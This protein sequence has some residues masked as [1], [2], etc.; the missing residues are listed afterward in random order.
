MASYPALD[1]R[2]L[3]DEVALALVDDFGPLAAEAD[4]E[5]LVTIFFSTPALRDEARQALR[6]GAPSAS[7]DSRDIDDGGWAARS[8]AA[9]TPVSVGRITVAPPWTLE[10]LN[11]ALGATRDTVI[12]VIQPSMGFGTGHH[13]S[14]RLCLAALQT[15][16]LDGVSVL[17]VGTG[18]GVLA[19]AA[20]QLGART[21]VGIDFDPDAIQSAQ[22]NH[23][24]NGSP[25]GVTFRVA[26]LISEEI[27][28]F[29]VVLANLT[30]ALLER[31]AARLRR[32]LTPSGVLIVSGLMRHERDGVAAAFAPLAVRWEA[33]ED[34]WVGLVLGSGGE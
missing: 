4:D 32:A 19:L 12:V 3:D 14:T 28:Q 26:D 23:V 2:G 13:A 5:G 22:E 29:D 8:Q 9:L 1:I 25:A 18:S 20:H 30:G 21:A 10:S 33:S 16:R 34:E 31:S 15:C 24:L 7:V 11:T 17:D 6:R 27:P